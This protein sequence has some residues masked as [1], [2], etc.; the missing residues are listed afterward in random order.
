MVILG[1]A[2]TA[3]GVAAPMLGFSLPALSVASNPEITLSAYAN[4][5]VNQQTR[6]NGQFGYL[7]GL[8]RIEGAQISVSIDGNYYNT[9]TTD[10]LGN[11]EVTYTPTTVGY[12][13]L[14]AEYAGTAYPNTSSTVGFSAYDPSS[15]HAPPPTVQPYDWRESFNVVTFSGIILMAAGL[16]SASLPSLAGRIRIGRHR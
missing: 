8:N 3:A 10:S 4:V 2:I 14:R 9:Y 6:L 16:I 5:P 1:A 7:T 12:H 11:F 13:E 15:G